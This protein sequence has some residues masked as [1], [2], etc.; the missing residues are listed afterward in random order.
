MQEDMPK[1]YR[2]I[3]KHLRAESKDKLTQQV[4]SD[5]WHADTDRV[6]ILPWDVA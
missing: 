1:L 6:Y 5:I 3:R 2:F 4:D